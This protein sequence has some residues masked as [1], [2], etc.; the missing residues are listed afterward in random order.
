M[1]AFAPLIVLSH[2]FIIYISI[3]LSIFAIFLGS[4]VSLSLE[5]ILRAQ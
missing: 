5:D 1:S 2:A 3:Y 4:H